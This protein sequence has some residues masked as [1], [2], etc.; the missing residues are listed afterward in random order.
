VLLVA[1]TDRPVSSLGAR[2]HEIDLA[3]TALAADEPLV[4]VGDGQLGTVAR[5]HRGGVGLDLVPAIAA[6]DDQ[7]DAGSRG[8]AQCQR[9]AGVRLQRLCAATTAASW[10]AARL[11]ATPFGGIDAISADEPMP[12][13]VDVQDREI[14]VSD[15]RAQHGPRVIRREGPPGRGAA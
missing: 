6:P 9:R 10:A 11:S 8:A 2:D 15:R 7:P 14:A 13:L 3:A 4:P 12:C 5:C 1:R